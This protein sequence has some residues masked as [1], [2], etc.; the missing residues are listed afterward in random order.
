MVGSRLKEGG[1]ISVHLSGYIHR[2]YTAVRVCRALMEAFKDVYVIRCPELSRDFGI[3]GNNLKFNAQ[4][5]RAILE[6]DEV[7]E[8]V[9]VFDRQGVLEQLPP[10][11]EAISI[12]NMEVVL[13][14]GW[15]RLLSRYF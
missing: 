15:E 13:K 2:T 12:N 8:K 11:G 4:D 3:A 10:E 6:R 1:A 7:P 9:I 5:I 14:K